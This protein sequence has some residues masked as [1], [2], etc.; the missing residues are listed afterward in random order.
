MNQGPPCGNIMRTGNPLEMKVCRLEMAKPQAAHVSEREPL[1]EK[2]D[3]TNN[4]ESRG[5]KLKMS[6]G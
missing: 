1:S 4:E 2:D 6:Q 3:V 5:Q